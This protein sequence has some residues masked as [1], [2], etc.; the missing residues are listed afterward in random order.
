MMGLDLP[1]QDPLDGNGAPVPAAWGRDA[2]AVQPV[3]DLA[4]RRAVRLHRQDER[5]QIG[6]PL[7]RLG[8][9][10]GVALGAA[11][12]LAAQVGG[13]AQLDA[14]RLGRLGALRI[15]RRSSCRTGREQ[16]TD[17]PNYHEFQIARPCPD[18]TADMF[19]AFLSPM[20]NRVNSSKTK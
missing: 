2:A 1:V 17:G 19:K 6:R 18:Y 13:I 10:R 5:E 11:V 9:L 14:A 20:G 4:E 12:E 7:G 15:H 16:G 3:G 8:R